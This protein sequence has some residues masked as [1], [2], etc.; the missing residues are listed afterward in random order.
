MKA[1]RVL[2]AIVTP[3]LVAGSIASCAPSV[4]EEPTRIPEPTPVS[5]STFIFG[6]SRDSV[7]LDPAVTPDGESFRVTGQCLEPPTSPR[8]NH[9]RTSQCVRFHQELHQLFLDMGL[10][11]REVAA[12]ESEREQVYQEMR[13]QLCTFAE[14]PWHD[15]DCHRPL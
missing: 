13:K 3:I 11:L 6:R 7:S 10:A 2:I 9:R 15:A 1:H 5:T 8:A 14:Q 12:D 4:T